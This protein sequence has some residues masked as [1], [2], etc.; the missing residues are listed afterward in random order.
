M[1]KTYLENA[2]TILDELIALTEDDI[3][4]IQAG[5]HSGVKASVDKKTALIQKFTNVKKQIDQSLLELSENGSKNLAEILDDEDKEKLASF[6]Q[7]L[8]ELHKINKEYAK[9]VLIVKDFLDGLL[10]TMFDNGSGTNNAYGDKKTT[11]ES[12]FKLNV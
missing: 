6:K 8:Q 3:T 2:N 7:R 10:N 1:I 4:Q 12:L 11:P 9:Y 5:K